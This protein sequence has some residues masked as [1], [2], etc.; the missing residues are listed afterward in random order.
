MVT[1]N[2]ICPCS[3]SETVLRILGGYH[4][5]FKGTVMRTIQSLEIIS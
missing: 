3:I 5:I 1:S 2:D 4:S